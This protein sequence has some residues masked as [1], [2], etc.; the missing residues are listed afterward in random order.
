MNIFSYVAFSKMCHLIKYFT[1]LNQNMLQE[2]I[3]S[4]ISST[5]RAN[6]INN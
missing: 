4:T 1:E 6:W 3:T 5:S 2:D